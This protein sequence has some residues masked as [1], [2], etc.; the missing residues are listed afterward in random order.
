MAATPDAPVRPATGLEVEDRVVAATLE[1]I[2]H[3]LFV[4]AW[5][6][7]SEDRRFAVTDPAVGEAIAHVADG[8]PQDAMDALECADHA[9]ADWAATATRTRAEVLYRAYDAMTQQA[10]ELALLIT[11]E[12]GKPLSESLAE[13]TYGSAYLQ[14]YAEE[15]V[16][17]SGRTTVSPDGRST[18]FTHREPVGPCLLIT[19]WNFPFAMGLRK[20]APAL[21]AGCTVVLKPA[22]LTPLSSLA[23]AQILA[24]AGLPPGVLN[25]VTSTGAREIGRALMADARLRKVSFTG[26]TEVGRQLLLQSA[27]NILRTSME[28]GGNAPLLVFDDADMA[29]AVEGAVLAKL[30]NGGQSCVAA[31]R[32]LVQNGIADEFVERFTQ[33]MADAVV[34]PGRDPATVV[35]PLINDSAVVEI[36]RL[37]DDAVHRGS[38]VLTGAAVPE[39]PGSFY[40]PTVLDR[41]PDEALVLHEEIFGPVAPIV[42]FGDER[43][44]IDRANTTPYGLVAYLFTE[45]L[46][47]AA[48]VAGALDVGMVG[49]NQGLVSNVAA[50]F[51]GVK[52]SGL[53]REGGPEGLDEYTQIKYVA[54]AAPLPV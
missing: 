16:R 14:W 21:A 48:R 43:E 1:S 37:V 7:A 10:D 13:V 19:P 2:P 27:S 29:R 50:P 24:D 45:S 47:R 33:R 17:A 6:P 52:Q 26:S 3:D 4:G 8:S 30:R 40:P 25:V 49:I 20:I 42:R 39:G 5:R 31:N 23:A 54:Q 28:L 9:R 38:K 32:I 35:G 11:L 41:V 51:G 34:G 36:T 46:D 12:M 44:A 15:A 53:G 18:I 22:A